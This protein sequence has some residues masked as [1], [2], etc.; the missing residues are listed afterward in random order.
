MTRYWSEH[1]FAMHK[2]VGS[3]MWI[4]SLYNNNNNM[5]V[6]ICGK[7]IKI[8]I[9][10]INYFKSKNIFIISNNAQNVP[11]YKNK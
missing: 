3:V 2:V 1:R 7:S 8:I 5:A 11:V 9:K 10:S 4:L 6:S